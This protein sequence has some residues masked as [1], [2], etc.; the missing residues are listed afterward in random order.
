MSWKWISKASAC[1]EIRSRRVSPRHVSTRLS[2]RSRMTSEEAYD[3]YLHARTSMTRL[4]PGDDEVI[5]LFE[6][7]IGKESALAPAYAG[8]AEAYAWKLFE[9]TGDPNR[10]EKLQKCK[11]RQKRRFSWIRCSRKHIARWGPSRIADNGIRLDK[12]S[13][14]HRDR[15]QFFG[16]AR[17]F[18]SLLL[19]AVRPHQGGSTGSACGSTKRSV[20]AT[21]SCRA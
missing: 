18:L 11:L 19:L 17:S 7:A 6:K 8:L 9:G 10:E 20:L 13:P 5:G 21:G 14:G 1:C 15:S 4:F 12:F 2:S 3:L 16:H